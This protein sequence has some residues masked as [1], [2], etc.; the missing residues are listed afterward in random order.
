MLYML[1]QMAFSLCFLTLSFRHVWP[2]QS[3]LD[4]R[5]VFSVKPAFRYCMYG[6]HCECSNEHLGSI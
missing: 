4:G 5:N 1:L 6:C 3:F 2:L